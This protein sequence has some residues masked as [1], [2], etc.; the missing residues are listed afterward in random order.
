MNTRNFSLTL[1][2][3]T[4]SLYPFERHWRLPKAAFWHILNHII[5]R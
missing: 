1:L 3:A 2:V 4:G 5:L